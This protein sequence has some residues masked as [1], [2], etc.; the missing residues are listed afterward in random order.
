M[1][2]HCEW[3]IKKIQE[4]YSGKFECDCKCCVERKQD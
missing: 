3:L 2:P 4:W 1:H